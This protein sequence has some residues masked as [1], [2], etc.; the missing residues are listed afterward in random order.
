VIW[1]TPH[2]DRLAAP[3]PNSELAPS[4]QSLCAF[5][6]LSPS[7]SNPHAEPD[8]RT[9]TRCESTVVPVP[10]FTSPLMPPYFPKII[11]NISGA[12]T[13]ASDSTMNFGVSRPT[14]P[15]VIFSFGVA[16]EYEP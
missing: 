15:Q 12:T 7:R 5:S 11:A 6:A 10:A 1:P 13:V 2:V 8:E 14:L 9:L 3:R 16:P 4:L